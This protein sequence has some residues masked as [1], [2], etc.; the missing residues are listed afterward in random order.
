MMTVRAVHVPSEDS[1]MLRLVEVQSLVGNPQLQHVWTDEVAGA[2]IPDI[3]GTLLGSPKGHAVKG[4]GDDNRS[5]IFPDHRFL[6][7]DKEYFLCVKG[8]GAQFDA[9]AHQH[10]TA[11]VLGEICRD[12]S[13]RERMAV[14]GKSPTRFITAERWYGCSPYGAQAPDN[15][16]LA[17]LASMR[18]DG[19]SI[20]GFR[21]CPVVAAIRLPRS[22]EELASRFHWYRRYYGPFWQEV[23]L[24]PSNVRVYFQSPVTF[25]VNTE[26]SF[27]MFGLRSKGD[28]DRFM[29][30]LCRSSLAALTLFA[31]TIRKDPRGGFKGLDLHDVW[32]D[33]DAVVAADGALHFADLEGV[34]DVRASSAEEA[35]ERMRDQ[36][37]H[38]ICEASFALEAAATEADRLLALGWDREER[39]AWIMET[40]QRSSLLDG[41]AR[42]EGRGAAMD[43]IIEP[44]IQDEGLELQ[45]ELFSE[46]ER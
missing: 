30:N 27:S 15:A 24:M 12:P 31:R 16:L 8:C 38:H 4:L 29:E 21:I 32:L 28:C 46:V 35:R 23:R 2:Y 17:L 10:L 6:I 33:K 45:L 1:S 11:P 14:M 19:D 5:V 41:Y 37:Y 34:E 26:L 44:A 18:A 40:M 42:A 7:G 9:F 3:M 13:L 25:G 20:A 43:L 36:C 22:V 39:K